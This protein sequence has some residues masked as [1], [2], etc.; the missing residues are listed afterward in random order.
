M[1]LEVWWGPDCLA[2]VAVTLG[3]PLEA[4]GKKHTREE[5][6]EPPA[7]TH[8]HANALVSNV[9][10]CENKPNKKHLIFTCGCTQTYTTGQQ[11]EEISDLHRFN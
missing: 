10:T 4:E 11:E 5:T 8:T 2:G 3:L 6:H 1:Y 9:N 7:H